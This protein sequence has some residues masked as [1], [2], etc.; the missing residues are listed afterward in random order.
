MT[1]DTFFPESPKEVWDDHSSW[2]APHFL[3]A[4]TGIVN[5]GEQADHEGRRHHGGDP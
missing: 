4:G 3:D 2:L 1:P 5:S